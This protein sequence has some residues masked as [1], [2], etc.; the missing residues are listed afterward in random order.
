[1]SVFEM[2]NHAR[3]LRLGAVRE[4]NVGDPAQQRDLLSCS[5]LS[6]EISKILPMI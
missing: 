1:M 2:D 6:L 4:W 3:P 5:A